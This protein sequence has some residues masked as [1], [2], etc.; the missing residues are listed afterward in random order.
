[1]EA[2]SKT[3]TKKHKSGRPKKAI[4]RTCII[5]IRVTSTEL[6]LIK[7]KAKEAGHTPSSWLR[8]SA[9]RA[10]IVAR[11][12]PS[13]V[14]HLRMLAGVANNLN[15]MTHLAHKEGLLYHQRDCREA[16]SK[17]SELLNR[18]NSD[19]RQSHDR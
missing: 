17:I 8:Q 1:M 2:I 3:E 7:G 4:K 10:N 15:Q 9:K 11:L 14:S 12:T 18:L 5:V 19:D 16:V 13:D 6:M